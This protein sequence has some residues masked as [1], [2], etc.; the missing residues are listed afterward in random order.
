MCGQEVLSTKSQ[1]SAIAKFN[2][3]R[4]ELE[5]KFPMREPTAEER[6]ELL[7]RAVNG[8]FLGYNSLA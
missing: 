6:I 3:L 4:A 8:V 1:R 7:Q 5:E 2:A